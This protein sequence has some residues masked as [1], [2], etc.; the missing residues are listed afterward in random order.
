MVMSIKTRRALFIIFIFL[1]V[2]AGT[3]VILYAQGFTVNLTTLTVE[4]TGAIYLEFAQGDWKG[5]MNYK[6]I[7]EEPRLLSGGVF[8]KN[9][10]PKEYEMRVEKTGFRPWIKK[11]EVAPAQ[12]TVAT[13]LFLMPSKLPVAEVI[14]VADV[15]NFWISQ[16]SVVY[17]DSQRVL[18]YVYNNNTVSL[19]GSSLVTESKNQATLITRA[20]TKKGNSY[21]LY[22]KRSLESSLNLNALFQNLIA[23]LAAPPSSSIIIEIVPHAFDADKWI[24]RASSGLFII[25][26]NR[27]DLTEI[28][29]GIIT[30]A[31]EGTNALYYYGPKTGLIRYDLILKNKKKIFDPFTDEEIVEIGLGAERH[32]IARSKTGSLYIVSNQNEPPLKL[33]HSVDKFSLT[34]D[35]KK[36]AYA[37]KDGTLNI[38]FLAD[39]YG[40]FQ[41]KAGA[42]LQIEP[43]RGFIPRSLIWYKNSNYLIA[44]SDT[45]PLF[46]EIDDAGKSIFYD[47]PEFDSSLYYDAGANVFFFDEDGK[48]YSYQIEE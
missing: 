23:R 48:M 18:H 31:K 10:L 36:L 7:K 29:P 38:Y 30:A 8:I 20:E 40:M 42:V 47:L 41:K 26:T 2:I 44:L 17:R 37:D 43:P 3:L 21:Y 14:G 4:K 1:F 15:K 46:I 27:L 19:R 5:F 6:P 22:D 24:V 39:F 12:V 28:E 35:L 9:L 34:N 33:A 45:T 13:D 32:I 25:D 16:E 11:L